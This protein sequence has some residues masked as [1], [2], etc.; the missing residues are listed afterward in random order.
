MNLYPCRAAYLIKR[1]LKYYRL[2]LCLAPDPANGL[3][4]FHTMNKIMD[5]MRCGKPIVS[6]DLLESRFSAMDAAI[7]IKNN[8]AIEFGNAII[9][10]L[11]DCELRKRMGKYGKER[12]EKFLKWDY[13]EEV[14]ISNYKKIFSI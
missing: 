13:S 8:D 2:H 12:V 4:E 14:L 3:N 6:F 9:R 5:Y 10:L 11:N 7:Y 1:F